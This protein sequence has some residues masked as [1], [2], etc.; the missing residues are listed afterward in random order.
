MGEGFVFHMQMDF[1]L[2]LKHENQTWF[3]TSQTPN[4][5]LVFKTIGNW[6]DK[7]AGNTMITNMIRKEIRNVREA[8]SGSN[9]SYNPLLYIP[10]GFQHSEAS[11]MQK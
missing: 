4:N 7:K 3:W 8:W 6:L 1:K 5:A 2:W 11:S 9:H 10:I